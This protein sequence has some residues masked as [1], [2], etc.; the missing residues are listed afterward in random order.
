MLV[1]SIFLFP[2]MFSTFP[3]TI[4]NFSDEFNLL[5]ANALCFD[6]SKNF[7]FGKEL[8]RKLDVL[9]YAFQIG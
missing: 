5:S 6:K 9:F 8:K 3:K 4:F 1:T 7:S 2:A